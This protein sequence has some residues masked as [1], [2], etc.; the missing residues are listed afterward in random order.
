[1]VGD[2][3]LAGYYDSCLRHL[4]TFLIVYTLHA[5][6]LERGD[7]DLAGKILVIDDDPKMVELIKKYLLRE[8]FQVMTGHTANEA[9]AM[10]EAEKPDLIILDILLP[11]MDGLETCQ[12]L[13]RDSLP[14]IR[15]A[16]TLP[17]KEINQL[18]SALYRT[19]ELLSACS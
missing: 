13:R 8:G 6:G 12:V 5:P 10:T 17:K 1:L 18:Y 11:G 16:G 15:Y 2:D 9:I 14:P 7:W 4:F 19:S 3:A